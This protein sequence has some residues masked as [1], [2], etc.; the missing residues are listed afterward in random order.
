MKVNQVRVPPSSCPTCG[1][2]WDGAT[3]ASNAAATPTPGD[4]SLC[5]GCGAVLRYSAEL[6]LVLAGDLDELRAAGDLSADQV[7]GIRM[8]QRF[9]RLS[10]QTIDAIFPRSRS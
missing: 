1:E 3:E 6:V 9:I 5:I 10:R 7:E 4:F 8:Q 2:K